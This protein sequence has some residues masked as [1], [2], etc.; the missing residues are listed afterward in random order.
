VETTGTFK[1]DVKG[2]G[3]H[4]RLV[5]DKLWEDTQCLEGLGASMGP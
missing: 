1:L 5:C 4:I 2:E 3:E